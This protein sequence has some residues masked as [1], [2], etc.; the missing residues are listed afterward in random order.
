VFIA[1]HRLQM[2]GMLAKLRSLSVASSAEVLCWRP[3]LFN[4]A[5]RSLG[6]VLAAIVAVKNGRLAT[7]LLRKHVQPLLTLRN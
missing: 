5:Y 7:Q 4:S 2:S 3:W 1:E 6:V